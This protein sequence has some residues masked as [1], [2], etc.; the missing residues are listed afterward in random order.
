MRAAK[1]F[2]VVATVAVLAAGLA[3][4]TVAN[5]AGGKVTTSIVVCCKG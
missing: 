2:A 4:A 3:P 1:R 5:Q